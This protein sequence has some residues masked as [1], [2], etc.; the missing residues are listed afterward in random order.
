MVQMKTINVSSWVQDEHN[1]IFPVGA[2]DKQMLWS[3]ETVE[4]PVK[5]KWPYLFKESINSYPDQYWTEVVA[6]IISNHLDIKVPPAFPA[7][8]EI[9]GELVPGV[10]MEWLYDPNSESLVHGGDFLKQIIP[11]FDTQTGKQ[12]NLKDML[13]LLRVLAQHAMLKTDVQEW[14]SDMAL[15]DALIGNTDRHQENWG[16]VYRSE[17]LEMSAF[18]D[19]GTSLG[20]E[21]F[22]DRVA[23]WNDETLQRYINKGYH[24]LRYKREDERA[25]IQ[26]FDLV[27][28]VSIREANKERM[29]EKL[30]GFD[31][32][33]VLSE[34]ESLVY[35]DSTIPF[36]RERFEWISRVLVARHQKLKE[37]LEL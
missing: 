31:I 10:L 26:L 8:R 35:V 30:S 18:Y 6:Y 24:H 2:R 21:R 9:D 13:R 4:E 25:R 1:G 27:E 16:F 15:F 3:P 28:I 20:H 5:P 34:V 23:T 17:Q 37:V 33:T 32:D 14:L 19:N 22:T 7:V 36:S 11:D 12:H 29:V